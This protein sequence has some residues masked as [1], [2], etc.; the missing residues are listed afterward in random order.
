MTAPRSTASSAAAIPVVAALVLC[1]FGLYPLAN[2]LSDGDAVQ[3]YGH[4]RT[5]WLVIGGS[6]LLV[7]LAVA[8][9]A[10]ERVDRLWN[11]VSGLVL[12]IPRPAFLAA[13]ALFALIASATL[14]IICFGRQPHNADE[15]AQLFHAKILLSGRLSLP[16]D[17]NPEFFGMDNMIDQG[18]WYSQFP[19]FGPAFLAIGIVLRA[20][21]S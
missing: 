10:G 16:A 17:P 19:V 4:A 20:A 9:F 6:M 5:F 12:R 8:R 1:V 18:R 7:L 11:A 2:T 13:T 3:W 21:W 15:V 14:A